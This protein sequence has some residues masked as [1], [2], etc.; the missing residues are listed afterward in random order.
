M[1]R[2]QQV[3]SKKL[4][5]NGTVKSPRRPTVRLL[6]IRPAVGREA[7]IH[8][9]TRKTPERNSLP[10]K[11]QS[12]EGARTGR[13]VCQRGC[14]VHVRNVVLVAKRAWGQDAFSTT[15]QRFGSS[16]GHR[17]LRGVTAGMHGAVIVTPTEAEPDLGPQCPRSGATRAHDALVE[18]WGMVGLSRRVQARLGAT[19]ALHGPSAIS[20][21]ES[22]ASPFRNGELRVG[23]SRKRKAS[24]TD[25]GGESCSLAVGARSVSACLFRRPGRRVLASRMPK[26]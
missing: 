19:G 7:R 14:C 24:L 21:S 10:S 26:I 11:T 20:G 13:K 9:S 1:K 2:F 23:A 8:L 4:T 16:R 15:G 6:A 17:P 25:H 3:A 18:A 12:S 22:S 5:R